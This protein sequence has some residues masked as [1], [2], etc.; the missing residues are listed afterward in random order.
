[1]RDPFEKPKLQDM[2]NKSKGGLFTKDTVT[3]K[4]QIQL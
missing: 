2:V 3:D 4:K 1:M